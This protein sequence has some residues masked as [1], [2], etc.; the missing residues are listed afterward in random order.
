MK[1]I[2]FTLALALLSCGAS[3][4]NAE[5]RKDYDACINR[6]AELCDPGPVQSQAGPRPE[7]VLQDEWSAQCSG[8]VS[9]CKD[10]GEKCEARA[11]MP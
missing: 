6:C 4:E 3:F 1:Y 5:C 10:L 8:C 9:S 2:L 11:K 7:Q